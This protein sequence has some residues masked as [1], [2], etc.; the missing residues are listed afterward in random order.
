M[1]TAG[2]CQSSLAAV[3][4]ARFPSPSRRFTYKI[5]PGKDFLCSNWQRSRA[6]VNHGDPPIGDPQAI[7]KT[8]YSGTFSLNMLFF[9]NK[10]RWGKGERG[11]AGKH[12][13]AIGRKRA[14]IIAIGAVYFLSLAIL[15]VSRDTLRL[16][17]RR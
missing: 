2:L 12:K 10:H 1:A 16:A 5:L 3:F 9:N 4:H 15:R 13:P 14:A 11:Q 17:A 8:T 6:V 7:R